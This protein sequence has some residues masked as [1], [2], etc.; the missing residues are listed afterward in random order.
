MTKFKQWWQETE[1]ISGTI[2]YRFQQQLKYIK[3]HLKEW[4][5]NEF[6]NIHQ[7]KKEL[8]KK[9]KDLQQHFILEGKT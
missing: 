5:I 9:M 3:A 1:H 6:G 4:N 8:E 7:E 2:M